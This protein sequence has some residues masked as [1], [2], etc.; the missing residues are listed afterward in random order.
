MEF[1][2]EYGLFFAK[3]IT[4]AIAVVVVIGLIIGIAIR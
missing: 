1:L 2:T 4:L 3:T